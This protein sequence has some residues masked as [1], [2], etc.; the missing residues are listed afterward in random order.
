[1]REFGR[2]ESDRIDKLRMRMNNYDIAVIGGGAS[3]TFFVAE[4]LRRDVNQRVLWLTG[5]D[6][7]GVAYAS[8]FESHLLNVAASRM[9]AFHDQPQHFHD[10]LATHAAARHYAPTD[11]V[12]RYLYGRYLTHLKD[13]AKKDPRLLWLPR[14]LTGVEKIHNPPGSNWRLLTREGEAFD[15]QRLVIATGLSGMPSE[16]S[17]VRETVHDPWIWFRE[18]ASDKQALPADRDIFVIGSGLTSMDVIVGLRDLGFHG[19]IHVRSRS[20]RWS[21]RH[22][23]VRS[24]TSDES[25]SLITAM[26]ELPTCRAY[27]QVVRRFAE[28]HPWRSVLDALRPHS[29]ELWT[30]LSL[31]E[32][33]RFL[34]HV[35][36]IWNRHRH[37]APT[38]TAERI[39]D[40]KQ[41]F[42]EKGR[43]SASNH[44]DAIVFDCRGLGLTSAR[45]WPG[46][47]TALKEHGVVSTGPLGIGVVSRQP[48]SVAVL[49]ALRFDDEFECTAIPE[50]RAQAR[51]VVQAWTDR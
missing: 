35:F 16:R 15:T 29:Q 41:V 42:I 19:K 40:D 37:R 3:G 21:E 30:A 12:P 46:Y 45:V 25:R 26:F 5:D 7:V 8:P 18:R 14:L 13:E 6:S 1:M 4:L 48:D 38:R 31:K 36:P 32:K 24:L 43:G 28:I 50:I 39:S 51:A 47:L 27:L 34:R 20:G 44:Q 23:V 11:Y 2:W 33:R 49:G 17:S 22:E 9:S 10:W